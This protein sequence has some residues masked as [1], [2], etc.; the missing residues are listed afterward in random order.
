MKI[1]FL[2]CDARLQITAGSYRWKTVRTWN[3]LPDALR[4]EDNLLKF[5]VGIKKW[6]ISSQTEDD[7]DSL[8]IPGQGPGPGLG[9]G[10]GPGLGQGPTLG[11]GQGPGPVLTIIA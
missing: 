5:K 6:L 1:T 7:R 10:P 3:R 4:Q 2:T 9:P 8:R 11:P